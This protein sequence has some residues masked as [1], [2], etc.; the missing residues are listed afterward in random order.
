MGGR[1]GRVIFAGV[2]FRCSQSGD[3]A[4]ELAVMCGRL[5]SPW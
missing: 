2:D 3:K 1:F 5:S 4:L